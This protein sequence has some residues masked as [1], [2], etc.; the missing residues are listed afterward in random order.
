MLQRVTKQAVTSFLTAVKKLSEVF[1]QLLDKLRQVEQKAPANNISSSIQ[2]IRELIAQTRSVASKVT[3]LLVLIV[4]C[5]LLG[6]PF[7]W[8]MLEAHTLIFIIS[9]QLDKQS[10]LEVIKIYTVLVVGNSYHHPLHGR[11]LLLQQQ[12]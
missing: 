5:I 3:R 9:Q 7:S 12:L 6:A 4:K 1:P 8:T 11:L 2:R 10:T